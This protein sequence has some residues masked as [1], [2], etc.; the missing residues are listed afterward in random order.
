M[1]TAKRVKE[2]LLPAAFGLGSGD[3]R[4]KYTGRRPGV[5]RL[6]ERL[7]ALDHVKEPQ[8]PGFSAPPG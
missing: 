4:M 6:R 3:R 7:E 1:A 2:S 5:P 8:A